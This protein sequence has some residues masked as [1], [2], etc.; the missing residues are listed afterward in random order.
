M[1]L[2]SRQYAWL[3]LGF[4]ALVIYGS[5]VPF[6]FR[7][8]AASEAAARLAEVCRSPL[9]V[10]S[11]SD[12]L[13][14]ILLF[15]PLGFLLM[16]AWCA[17]RPRWT[18]LVAALV[19]VPAC[20]LLS[21]AIEFTQLYFPPR[22]TSLNDVAAESLGGLLGTVLWLA[23]GQRLTNTARDFWAGWSA[24]GRAAQLLPA[25]LALLVLVNVMPLD[26]TLSPV[27]IYHKYRAGRVVLVPFT[28][29]H[30]GL[31]EFVGKQCWNMACF[32]PAG[33]LLAGLPGPAWRSRRAWLRVL[34]V[35][36]ALAALVEG[37]KL[38]VVPRSS[39]ATGLITGSLAVLAGWA[40][41]RKDEV[42]RMKDEAISFQPSAF[43]L[44]PGVRPVLLV[45]W[46][47][48]LVLLNWEPFNFRSDPA[49]ALARLRQVSPIP[50]A[51]YYQGG[52][53]DAYDQFLNK[54][55]MFLPLGALLTPMRPTQ[56]RGTGMLIL[57]LC[58]ALAAVFEAG[59]LF[60]PTRYTSVTDVLVEGLGGW[61]GFIV[62]SRCYH[63]L[64][65][66]ATVE[67]RG[68]EFCG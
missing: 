15:I 46:L 30:V 37:L 1:V 27:E 8:L 60:L 3:A 45:A 58:L 44:A 39:D 18:G 54:T 4:L 34:G 62:A 6:H 26:L 38:F 11:R 67:E 17:D 16:A 51:D 48:V 47:G 68:C 28:T 5:L 63:A 29:P 43:S 53:L 50:F 22:V 21:A 56:T 41:I 33:L 66:P 42:G 35:G 10:E 52:Y 9:R 23:A 13:A 7:P 12:W 40:L 36:L 14:N 2:S 24:R 20:A 49:V 59:Q 61:L 64:P 32:L 57:G 25:Y 19:V 31:V 55:L 65:A